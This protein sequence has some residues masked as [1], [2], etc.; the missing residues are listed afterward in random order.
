MSG[1]IWAIG[2]FLVLAVL[3]ILNK[4]TGKTYIAK[5]L[6]AFDYFV[7]VLWS[8]D[9][10][11]TISSRCGLYWRKDPP[12]FWYVLHEA[13]NT[14]QTDHCELAIASDYQRALGA[15]KLLAPLK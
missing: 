7:C 6:L 15:T 14:L 10:D 13:L 2:I 3:V 5:A 9:F 11:L 4:I 12:L 1:W 8:R